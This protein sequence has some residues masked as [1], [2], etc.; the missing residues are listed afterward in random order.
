MKRFLER[1]FNTRKPSSA[2]IA[3]ERLQIIVSHERTKQNNPDFIAKLQ[4]E[5]V[6][7]IAK[8]VHI[9]PE[10]VKVDLGQT[11]NRSVLELNITLPNLENAEILSE[12]QT[13]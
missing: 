13:A 11:E 9:D 12:E 3:K 10:A 8:Y 2:S 6:N 7:V 4:K 5:L 1:I